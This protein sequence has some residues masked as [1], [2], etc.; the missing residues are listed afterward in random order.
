[1]TN[2][3]MVVLVIFFVAGLAIVGVAWYN[4]RA[5]R[6]YSA[7]S[8]AKTHPIVQQF[9]SHDLRKRTLIIRQNNDRYK[10]EYQHYSETII[11]T[12]GEI[13]GWQSAAK[14]RL[15]DTLAKAVEIA[16]PWVHTQD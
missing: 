4:I 6:G 10:V 3:V 1:M 11:N 14:Q 15:C 2:G 5:S 8:E 13:A 12:R 7:K 16:E 9:Y